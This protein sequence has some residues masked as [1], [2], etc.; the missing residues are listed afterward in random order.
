MSPN[1]HCKHT[2]TKWKHHPTGQSYAPVNAAAGRKIL[3][4]T[5]AEKHLKSGCLTW[6]GK[7]GENSERDH[8]QLCESILHS[9]DI[10]QDLLGYMRSPKHHKAKLDTK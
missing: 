5:D 4:D 3:L 10:N 9:N 1:S 2:H 6:Q 7:K 8:T